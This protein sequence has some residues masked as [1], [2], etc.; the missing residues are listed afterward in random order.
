MD[1]LKNKMEQVMERMNIMNK[2]LNSQF[3]KY[4]LNDKSETYEKIEVDPETLEPVVI[5][6][7][8][9]DR[10]LTTNEI[11][12]KYIKLRNNA[13]KILSE[14]IRNGTPPKVIRKYR[15]LIELLLT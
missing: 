2:A 11:T 7:H 4:M 8:Y 1:V 10:N 12:D 9:L 15:E 14:K 13:E 3:G 6:E 5:A